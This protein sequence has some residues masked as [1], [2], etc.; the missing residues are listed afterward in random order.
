M[1]KIQ[2]IRQADTVL[3][4]MSMSWI[5]TSYLLIFREGMDWK[6]SVLHKGEKKNVLSTAFVAEYKM[7]IKKFEE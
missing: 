5:K 6:T 1:E 2:F 7:R 4:G 3:D